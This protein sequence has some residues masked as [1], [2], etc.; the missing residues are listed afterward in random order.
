MV[1]SFWKD[2]LVHHVA[3]ARWF[4]EATAAQ[5]RI[6]ATAAQLDVPTLLLLAG[7]DRIV[8]NDASSALAARAPSFIQLHRFDGL[9]HELFLEPEWPEVV[10]EIRAFLAPAAT[11]DDHR[12]GSR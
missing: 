2:P 5:Q 7:A 4:A 6:L 12:V 9:F 1:A 10:A 3:T 8:V 11:R